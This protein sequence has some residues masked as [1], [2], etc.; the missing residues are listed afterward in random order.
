[1]TSQEFRIAALEKLLLK[2]LSLKLK[3]YL[4][5]SHEGSS[6]TFLKTMSIF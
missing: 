6:L 5:A 4:L 1:M 2:N 3:N